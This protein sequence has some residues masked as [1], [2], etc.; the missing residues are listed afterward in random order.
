[1]R[2]VERL[3]APMR[4]SGAISIRNWTHHPPDGIAVKPAPL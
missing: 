2:A 3:R 1:M 4:S